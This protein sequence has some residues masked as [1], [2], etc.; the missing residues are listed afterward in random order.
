[1]SPR[2]LF[3]YL[4]LS[5]IEPLLAFAKPPDLPMNMQVDCRNR[6]SPHFSAGGPIRY[7]PPAPE[8]P[9]PREIADLEETEATQEAPEQVCPC[10]D[11]CCIGFLE[12][13][14]KIMEDMASNQ[15]EEAEAPESEVLEVMPKEKK[16]AIE[17][18]FYRVAEEG[19]HILAIARERLGDGA[20]WL[21]IYRLN[22][23]LNPRMP[24]PAG[25]VLRMPDTVEN[26]RKSAS[27][28]VEQLSLSPQHSR[29]KHLYRVGERC[30]R[31]G[32]LDMA[33]NC[34]EEVCRIAPKSSYGI[35]ASAQLVRMNGQAQREPS[36]RDAGE[37][38][39]TLA[40]GR[41]QDILRKSFVTLSNSKPI[42]L[43]ADYATTWTEGDQRVFLL[44]GEV[45]IEQGSVQLRMPECVVWVNEQEKKDKGIYCL[46]VYGE[47]N[48]MVKERDREISV[49]RVLAQL[50]TTSEVRIKGRGQQVM[51]LSL[52][53][54]PVFVRAKATIK[55]Q[56][57]APTSMNEDGE[58]ALIE[59][60]YGKA[61]QLRRQTGKEPTCPFRRGQGPACPNPRPDQPV[62]E[63][64]SMSDA[65]MQEILDDSQFLDT[66]LEELVNPDEAEE[67]GV[68]PDKDRPEELTVAPAPRD[69]TIVEESQ[70]RVDQ[71]R[72]REHRR[73]S[74]KQR[75]QSPR[76][77]PPARVDP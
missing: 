66:H 21:E 1:M 49:A 39:E 18:G 36:A 51:Q 16:A 6:Q 8:Y 13:L 45:A 52:P 43:I 62:N 11:G 77:S 68:K 24:I 32:D 44:R 60:I 58:Q 25:T 64:D 48:V 12:I 70:Q 41:G 72:A 23:D 34:Y 3:A 31:Q 7:L 37:A 4:V 33:R 55:E 28:K 54:D 67:V 15:A 53:Q 63:E 17:D 61:D 57:N 42:S 65:E 10:V 5:L 56:E 46:K 74:V 19:E 76:V 75:V 14:S 29:A 30:R 35:L 2:L 59:E 69:L 26:N 22:P 40:R 20:R 73:R 27:T 50:V 9:L 47:P 38:Q 71:S